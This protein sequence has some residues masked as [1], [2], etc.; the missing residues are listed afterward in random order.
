[1]SDLLQQAVAAQRANNLDEAERLYHQ[2]LAEQPGRA[3]AHF[4]LGMICGQ[5]GRAVEALS[6]FRQAVTLKPDF[7]EAWFML[8]EFADQAGLHDLNLLAGEQTVKLLPKAPR[9]WLRYGLAL[10]RL[11]RDE[12]ACDAYRR[13]LTLDPTLVNAW[14]NLCFSSKS[15]GRVD[16]A[17]AAIRLAITSAGLTFDTDENAEERYSYP[18]YHLALI[19]LL[20][21]RYREGFSYF[22][23][24]FKGGT[25]WRRMESSRPLWRG[26]DLKGKTILVTA[27]QG[28]GDTLMVARYVPLLKA[29]GARV[30][31]Q[32]QPALAR[33]FRAWPSADAVIA[34]G[35]PVGDAFDT[36]VPIFDLPYVFGTTLETVPAAVPYLPLMQP[37]AKTV[38]AGDGRPKVGVIW[39]G[40]PGNIRGKNRTLPLAVFSELFRE[41]GC[42]FFNLTRDIKPGDAD[43]LKSHGVTDLDLIIT[44]D[45]ATAHLAGGMGKKT[46]VLLPF[47]ADWRWGLVPDTCA[48]Y[49]TARLFKQRQRDDWSDA[50]SAVHAGL[51]DAL[52][53]WS[54]RSDPKGDL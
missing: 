38:L 46:W 32:V 17:E 29:R 12:E 37:E 31:F 49:P 51:R 19:D 33:L 11:G 34:I 44:C 9:A 20:R 39:A 53:L 26:A 7:A 23:S 13:A 18:H 47:V 50:V 14:V 41:T 1:M 21:G 28:F 2:A 3:D 4:N 48:W 22:R 5:Q 10:S 6:E 52:A 16:E 8:C 30:V 25:D 42:Q 27:E 36:H 15:L 45:T 24:R 35:E 43:L 40:Q 54:N